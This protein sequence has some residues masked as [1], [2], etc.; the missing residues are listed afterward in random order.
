MLMLPGKVAPGQIWK[1]NA[2]E[3]SVVVR[4]VDLMVHVATMSPPHR[5]ELQHVPPE[6]PQSERTVIA[7]PEPPQPE[8]TVI[9]TKADPKTERIFFMRQEHR[10]GRTPPQILISN[11][12]IRTRPPTLGQG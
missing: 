12:V 2:P 1:P 8:R 3:L 5:A 7:P 10:R 9:A 4:Q 11:A 6:P